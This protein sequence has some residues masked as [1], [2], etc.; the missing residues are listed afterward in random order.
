MDFSLYDITR[1]IW[2][3][4]TLFQ[5]VITIIALNKLKGVGPILM[6]I[7]TLMVIG[8]MVVYW[9]G[10]DSVAF[11]VESP[12]FWTIQLI[13]FLGRLLFLTGLLVMVMQDYKASEPAM[14]RTEF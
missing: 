4:V 7:G 12:G 5:L 6:L 9:V 2:P 1:F 14:G 11:D 13:S 8:R 10:L 3:F